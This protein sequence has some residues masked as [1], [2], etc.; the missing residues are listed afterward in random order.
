MADK[1]GGKTGGGMSVKGMFGFQ[2]KPA[3]STIANDFDLLYK[4]LVAS[5]LINP[6]DI[7][8]TTLLVYHAYKCGITDINMISKYFYMSKAIVGRQM[9]LLADVKSRVLHIVKDPKTPRYPEI[10]PHEVN[11]TILPDIASIIKMMS[12]QR[13]IQEE[14]P[15]VELPMDKKSKLLRKQIKITQGQV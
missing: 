4:E 14:I 10:L 12:E 9:I 13:A 6:K 7:S 3:N 5:R 2:I 15:A 11:V 1:D 8:F